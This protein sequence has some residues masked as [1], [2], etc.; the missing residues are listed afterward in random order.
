M[1]RILALACALAA[2]CCLQAAA[3]DFI[4]GGDLSG[5]SGY[6]KQ[7]V[8]FCDKDGTPADLFQ[9]MKDY[10]MEGIR[11]RVWVDPMGGFCAPLDVLDMAKKAQALGM[12]IMI[13]FHYSDWW[14]DPGKQNIPKRW[15]D[16]SY[17]QMKGA[18]YEH[19]ASTLQLLRN[20]GID[21][22]WVQVGNETTNGFLWPMGHAK[23]NPE[24]YAGLMRA[25]YDAVKAVMPEAI[26]IAHLDNGWDE[27]LYRWNFDILKN[28]GAKWDMIGMSLYPYW[29][30]QDGKVKSEDEALERCIRNIKEVKQRYGTDVMIVETGVEAN[31]PANG[32]A[33]IEKLLKA[34]A[35]ETDGICKGVWYWAPEADGVLDGYKLGAFQNRKPTEI[36]DAFRDFLKKE[37]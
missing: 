22:T 23:D 32:R 15:K 17:E 28:G 26:V 25:G 14:A 20:A 16:M 4:L 30:M 34:A 31:D 35:T 12:P 18:V 13:D 37:K 27:E 8:A 11:L 29:S 36:M 24:Q 21:V 1:K 33:F 3:P 6:D 9:L 7:G 19:T 2:V 5:R 10:G